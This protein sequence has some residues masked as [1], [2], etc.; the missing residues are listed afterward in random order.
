[1]ILTVVQYLLFL[2]VFDETSNKLPWYRNTGGNDMALILIKFVCWDFPARDRVFS[3]IRNTSTGLHIFMRAQR[4]SLVIYNHLVAISKIYYIT[5]HNFW[6]CTIYITTDSL[7]ILLTTSCKM[8]G[9]IK[10][11]SLMGMS[12]MSGMNRYS[13]TIWLDIINMMVH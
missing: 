3:L 1:M 12:L 7:K 13:F 9:D 4:A 8:I 10:W 2:Q 5:Y 6:S 11:Y